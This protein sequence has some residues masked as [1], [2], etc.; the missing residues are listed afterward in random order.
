MAT[1]TNRVK[2][3]T[4]D[5]ILPKIVDN[6]LPESFM[7]YRYVSMGEK[8]SGEVMKKPVKIAKNTQGGSFSG[9][10]FHNTGTAETRILLSYDPRGYEIPV[11]IPGLE[12][13]VNANDETKVI[14]LVKAELDS[15]LMDAVDDVAG[16]LYNDGTGNSSKDFNGLD[17]LADDGTTASSIGSQSRTT[18]PTL[19]GTRTASGGTVS[20]S[21]LATL[22]SALSSGGNTQRSTVIL[23]S[24]T[25]QNYYE[26]LLS[27]TVRANY[28]ANGLPVVTRSSK[29]PVAGGELKGTAG[30]VSYVYRGIPWVADEKAPTGTIWMLNEN[31]LKWYALKDPDLQQI[32][33]GD[34]HEGVAA[35][36]PTDN[37]GFQWT[38]F[39]RPEDQYAEVAHVYLLGNF[40]TWQP[41]RQGRLTGVLGI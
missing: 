38:N 9:L 37:I 5:R 28:D 41:R 10:D 12:K 1:F 21:K 8:W 29:R 24:E 19:A 4:Q 3:I 2:S 15:N 40:T 32:S 30:Y 16:I 35:D 6:Y 17:N 20:L 26:S 13:A 27:P 31:Y 7:L 39:I 11:T 14:N 23:S 34:T 33:L 22:N 18:Y 36:A 25:E